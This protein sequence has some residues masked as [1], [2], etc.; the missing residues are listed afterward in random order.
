MWHTAP[1]IDKKALPSSNEQ[2]QFS[3]ISKTW[4][5]TRTRALPICTPRVLPIENLSTFIGSTASSE[6]VLVA[7]GGLSKG[8]GC[9]LSALGM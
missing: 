8:L 4:K 6:C 5:S 3:L 7:S 9:G 2:F 1:T